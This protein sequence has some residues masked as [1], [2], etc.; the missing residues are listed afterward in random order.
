MR[1]RSKPPTN[2]SGDR[3]LNSAHRG[4]ELSAYCAAQSPF[5]TIVIASA[6]AVAVALDPCH[7][8]HLGP[9]FR[10]RCEVVG[11]QAARGARIGPSIAKGLPVGRQVGCAANDGCR[12]AATN[13]EA[14][15]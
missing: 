11:R 14:I 1:T 15:G 3:A 13:T 8:G 4:I 6:R 2:L 5:C 12:L 9:V 10:E 7:H